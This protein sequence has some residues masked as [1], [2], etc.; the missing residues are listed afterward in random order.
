M[1][2]KKGV[3]LGLI[4]P[5]AAVVFA[6]VAVFM[7]FA[8]AATLTVEGFGN[9]TTTSWTGAQLTFGYTSEVGSTITIKTEVFKFS[10]MNLLPYIL[11]AAGAVL[12]LLAMFGKK[13]A[14]LFGIVAAACYLVGGVFF[15]C[16]IPFALPVA[17][18][19]LKDYSLGAGAIVAGIFSIIPALIIAANAFLVK[20]K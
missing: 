15:F 9:S 14:K 12:S 8:P 10:F 18:N 4:L 6:V 16:V 20:K 17:E 11:V 13:A 7:M 5:L 3:N 1:A 2:K 19:M